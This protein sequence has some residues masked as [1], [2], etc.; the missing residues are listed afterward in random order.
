MVRR[1]VIVAFPD[2]Q[3]LDVVGPLEVF[4]LGERLRGET[5]YKLEV[6]TVTGE[7]FASSSGLTITPH[8]RLGAVRG[9]IDTVI[10]AGGRGTPDSVRDDTLVNWVRR[11]AGRCRRVA[12]VCTGAFVLAQAGLLDGR[13]ATT[14]W[15]VC[16][17]LAQA[18]PAVDVDPDPIFI[19]DGNVAT[20]AGVTAG[21]DLA[22][23]FVEED[24][25]RELALAVARELVLFV[26]RPGGQSQ[27][28]AQLGAQQAERAGLRDLQAWIAERPNEDLSVS[29]LAE[30]C[31]MSPRHF[32]RA[33]RDEIGVTPAAYVELTRVEH[34]RRLLETTDLGFAEVAH[35]SGFGSLD[36]MRRAFARR[37]GVAPSDYR[38]RF[39][40][41]A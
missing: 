12:S 20:S 1:I 40:V 37:L 8:R 14:H 39:Q 21:M 23:A 7:P 15:S 34:A 38:Q 5:L 35:S 6:A 33:F 13:R 2:V 16:V 3:L 30:R 26:R 11:S 10:V 24:F 4:S 9:E 28:S 41:P 17:E 18:Y 25:G 32:A 27:F 22:L 31:A 19:R 29:V 36:T